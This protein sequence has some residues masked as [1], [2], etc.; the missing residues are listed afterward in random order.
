M[1]RLQ[2]LTQIYFNPN[3]SQ[4]LFQPTEVIYLLP[5]LSS[6]IHQQYITG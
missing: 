5:L 3:P 6:V 2:Y 1:K 4:I